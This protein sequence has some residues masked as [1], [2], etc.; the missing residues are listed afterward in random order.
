MILMQLYFVV[1][2][3]PYRLSELQRPSSRVGRFVNNLVKPEWLILSGL[4][5]MDADLRT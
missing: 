5:D 1:G 4:A 2:F 3:F